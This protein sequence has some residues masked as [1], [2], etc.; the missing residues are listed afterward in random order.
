M[1]TRL[2][3]QTVRVALP[4]D[5]ADVP[6]RLEWSTQDIRNLSIASRNLERKLKDLKKRVDDLEVLGETLEASGKKLLEYLKLPKT[7]NEPTQRVVDLETRMQQFE[8]KMQQFEN[9]RLENT[10]N[11]FETFE[12]RTQRVEE[13]KADKAEVEARFMAI[14]NGLAT[15][16][17][18]LNTV[19]NLFSDVLDKQPSKRKKINPSGRTL[20]PRGPKNRVLGEQ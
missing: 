7:P 15:T 5:F 12:T 19:H 1:W 11:R 6:R 13:D 10:E 16:A 17:E 8:N 20:R 2:H 18:S 14:E 3:P 4:A 9:H